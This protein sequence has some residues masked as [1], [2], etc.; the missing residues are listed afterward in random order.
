MLRKLLLGLCL[1]PFVAHGAPAAPAVLSAP[2]SLT[3]S[4]L[5]AVVA[6][7]LGAGF[8]GV[9][10]VRSTAQTA[11]VVRTYGIAN[12]DNNLAVSADTPFQIGSIT[13]WLSAV[14][15]LRLVDQGKLTLDAPLGKMLPDMP[16]HTAGI[17]LRHLLSNTAGLPNGVKQEFSKDPSIADLKLT[18]AEAARRFGAG[19]PL[20]AP[21]AAWEYSPTA[22]IIVAA[23]VERAS[24]MAFSEALSQL[25]LTPAKAFATAVPGKP[26]KDMPGAALAYKDTAAGAPRELNLSPHVVYVA[27]SGTVHSTAADLAKLAHAVYETPLLSAAS[28]AELSRIVVPEQNYALGGRVRQLEL[29]GRTRMIAWQTGSTGGYKSLLAYV[30]GEGKTVVILNNTSKSQDA[31]TAAGEQILKALY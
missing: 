18:H 29:G 2:G 19:T 6:Q 23:V 21:G 14:V 20:F 27:A 1:L 25:V 17:T 26:F 15:V 5:D 31:L 7:H 4:A 11:P 13:K 9:V 8:S 10:L 30:P 28:R 3:G 12:A 16:A 24:G 22:W